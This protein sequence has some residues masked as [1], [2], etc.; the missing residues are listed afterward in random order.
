MFRDA[1]R[2]AG[3]H[4]HTYVECVV[5]VKEFGLAPFT[6]RRGPKRSNAARRERRVAHNCSSVHTITILISSSRSASALSASE[7][8]SPSEFVLEIIIMAAHWY[9]RM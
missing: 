4:I 2:E 9:P 7:L 5:R 6:I 1:Q 8:V 3:I